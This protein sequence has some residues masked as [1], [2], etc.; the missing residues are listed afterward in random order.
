[1]KLQT[2]EQLKT[3]VALY[4]S[5]YLIR[6]SEEYIIRYYPDNEM[7][8]PMHMSMGQEAVSAAVCHAI[9]EEGQIFATYRSHAAFLA[10]TKDTDAFFAELY[11]KVTGYSEGKGGSMHLMQ[12][13]SGH[14]CSSA[15]VSSCLAPAVG[16]AFANRYL[17]KDRTV[18]V[19]FGDG[20]LDE[21]AFWE[22]LNAACSMKIPLLF[23]CEDNGYAVHTSTAQ[24]QGYTSISD[25]VKTFKCLSYFDE[26]NDVESLF[27][28]AQSAAKESRAL[29]KPAFLHVRCC[30]YLEHVGI[31][32]DF[33]QGYR[34]KT[35]F[36]PFLAK[37]SLKL[38]RAR[39][40]A[41][42]IADG[43]IQ[44]WEERISSQIEASIARAQKAPSPNRS[45]LTKGIFA[46]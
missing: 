37:D 25:V 10:K 41:S 24:R 43:E 19:F 27:S 18:A 46:P 42:G 15:I 7:R 30:R 31:A 1:M 5:L 35:E 26:S 16:A 14:L 8:T 9:G 36:E 21:G 39:L 32:E 20:A 23:V 34:P 6:R 4:Q 45:H 29:S 33:D 22:S 40:Q 38:Q 12:P 28:T 2:D 44:A 13:E 3:R 17:K 11:G